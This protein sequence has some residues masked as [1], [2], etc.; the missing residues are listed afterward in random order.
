MEFA[1]ALA[2]AGVVALVLALRRRQSFRRLL[3][4]GIVRFY[5]QFWH[6]WRTPCRSTLPATGPVILISNHTCS[7]DPTFLQATC[8][9][10][11]L[12]WLSSKEHYHGHPLIRMFLDSL[13]CVPVERSGR[14]AV[15]ARLALRRLE[16]GRALCLFPEGNLSGVAR[17]RLR[18]PKAGAAW[19]ALRS[20]APVVPAY[21]D[22]GP[23]THHLVRSWL[24]PSR[25]PVRVYLGQP[26]HLVAF[27]GR[28]VTRKLVEEVALYLMEQ[29]L[30]LAP[31]GHLPRGGVNDLH[32]NL[33]R[34]SPSP[35]AAGPRPG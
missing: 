2:V 5:V 21:I 33:H 31:K 34:N 26:F 32:S 28:P 25:R 23:R 10:R 3:F 11:I 15:A 18:S 35:L 30:A 29:I 24:V 20:G 4:L 7:A 8:D 14:D 6:R 1:L 9:N 27:R 22:G 16:A 19:L 13:A 17:G 12:S